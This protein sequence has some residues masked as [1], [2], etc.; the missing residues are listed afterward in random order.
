M[1]G[2]FNSICLV[3]MAIFIGSCASTEHAGSKNLRLTRLLSVHLHFLMPL[4]DDDNSLR[5][6]LVL[7]ASAVI[8]LG[9]LYKKSIHARYANLLIRD[10]N[11][12]PETDVDEPK[13][14]E[15]YATAAGCALGTDFT[16]F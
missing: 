7:Q 3:A 14:R 6:P 12:P 13:P 2:P 10:L 9:F 16:C 5:I 11:R 8:S 4:Q 1:N 15:A